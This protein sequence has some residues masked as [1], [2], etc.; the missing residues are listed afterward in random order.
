M[1]ILP[2]RRENHIAV[3]HGQSV[4]GAGGTRCCRG[5]SGDLLI[6]T[7]NIGKTSVDIEWAVS[8]ARVDDPGDHAGS[9]VR[10]GPDVT[11]EARYP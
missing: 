4:F 5:K 1:T 11:G 7:W 3:Y 6:E 2:G 10:W 9:C 8:K